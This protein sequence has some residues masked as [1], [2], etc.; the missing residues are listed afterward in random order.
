MSFCNHDLCIGSQTLLV[1]QYNRCP[2]LSQSITKRLP[3]AIL[4]LQL[5]SCGTRGLPSP[6]LHALS[7]VP[8]CWHQLGLA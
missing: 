1:K 3:L 5:E 2:R 7:R 6:V 8:P 4:Q